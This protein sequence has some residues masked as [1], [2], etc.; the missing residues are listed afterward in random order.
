ML[1][2]KLSSPSKDE[3]C[4]KL[5]HYLADCLSSS[6]GRAI[7][8]VYVNASNLFRTTYLLMFVFYGRRVIKPSSFFGMRA[9]EHR[10]RASVHPDV[11]TNHGTTDCHEMIAN[12]SN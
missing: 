2:C 8:R 9:W 11:E 3:R 5:Y 10:H 6:Q 4:D 1:P 12:I 7:P